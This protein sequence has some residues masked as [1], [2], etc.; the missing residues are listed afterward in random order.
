MA[1]RAVR[2]GV[3]KKG[4][5]PLD[6][7]QLVLRHTDPLHVLLLGMSCKPLRAHIRDD[8]ALWRQLFNAW[9]HKT[10]GS[11]FPDFLAR[12]KRLPDMPPLG[13]QATEIA[14]KP[15]FNLVVSKVLRLHYIK[16]CGVC[17]QYRRRTDPVWALN[18][19]LCENCWRGN[20]V[21]NV[22]LHAKYDLSLVKPVSPNE[23]VP[24]MEMC[25]G[26]V[27]FFMHGGSDAD[28]KRYTTDPRDFDRPYRQHVIFFW[29][30]H[31]R[32]VVDL[33]ELYQDKKHRTYVAHLLTALV[34]RRRV[35]RTITLS[36]F[37]KGVRDG[38]AK[39]SRSAKTTVLNNLQT[40]A[41]P[42][43]RREYFRRDHVAFFERIFHG[44]P[45]LLTLVHAY[46]GRLVLA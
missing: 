25:F 15:R 26:K 7:W 29:E 39:M 38:F 8:H 16:R 35:Q 17:G 3:V 19:R 22:T 27:F 45:V 21:S 9:E 33:E 44:S 24:F 1:R 6:A 13:W 46:N 12:H 11:C 42:A 40:K 18:M 32:Q 37:Q 36:T 28:R 30:P 5:L 14:D 43:A 41:I 10:G 23:T 34:R 31:V 2:R 4:S 20:L